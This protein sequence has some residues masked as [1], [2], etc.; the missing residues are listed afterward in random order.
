M[1]LTHPGRHRLLAI[2][3]ALVALTATPSAVAA[4]LDLS[5]L[6][7]NVARS[8][9]AAT[10]AGTEAHSESHTVTLLTGDQVTVTAGGAGPDTVSVQGPDG[11]RA[12]A[13]ITR[14]GEDTYVYP[15][16]ADTYVGAGLLDPEL[17]N[18]TRLLADGYGDTHADGLPLIVSYASAARRKSDATS[19]PEGATGARALSSINSTALVQDRTRAEAFWSDLTAP[20]AEAES[21]TAAESAPK[22]AGGIQKV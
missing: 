2:T 4:D 9:S 6:T 1:R 18:V 20:A 5:T 17:F 13:R 12:D 8:G 10:A 21:A 15:S 11:L 19:L 22:L 3:T 16:S 14:Q 7:D